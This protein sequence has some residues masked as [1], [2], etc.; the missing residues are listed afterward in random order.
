MTPVLIYFAITPAGTAAAGTTARAGELPPNPT[1]RAPEIYPDISK[2][3]SGE[4]RSWA[5]GSGYSTAPEAD[6]QVVESSMLI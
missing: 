1:V 2:S 5:T 6:R 4:G 3:G